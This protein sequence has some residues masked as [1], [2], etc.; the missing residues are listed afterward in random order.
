MGSS[1]PVPAA[2]LALPDLQGRLPRERLLRLLDALPS[3]ARG[4]WVMAAAGGGKSVLMAQW[5]QRRQ[6]QTD[7]PALWLRLDA[8]DADPATLATHLHEAL[9]LHGAVPGGWPG[10]TREQLATPAAALRRCMRA[11]CAALPP[12]AT[13]V[14]DDVHLLPAASPSLQALPV[15]LDELRAGQT[16]WLLSRDEPPPALALA[17]AAGGLARVD[18]D[19]LRFDTEELAAWLHAA[20][21]SDDAVT[22]RQR[23][24]GWPLLLAMAAASPMADDLALVFEQALWST[25]DADACTLLERLAWLPAAGVE[26]LGDDGIALL[27][28]LQRSGLPVEGLA[29]D[30]GASCRYRLHDLLRDDARR[31]QR[32]RLSPAA[33]SAALQAQAQALQALGQDEAAWPLW[34]EAA[35]ADAAAWPAAVA[36]L[37]ALAPRWLATQQLARLRDAVDPVPE[38][39][40][41]AALWAALAQAEAPRSPARARALADRAAALASPAQRD[42]QLACQ[43]LAIATH[44]QNFDDTR[45]LAD[46]VAALQGLGVQVGNA[47]PALALAVWSALFL[48]DP[49]H[50]ELSRWRQRVLDLLHDERADPN[51]RPRAAMLMA[52]EGWYNGRHADLLQLPALVQGA[53]S[54]PGV[55]PYGRLLWGLMR[56]Y[57]AWAGA[58]WA[59]GLQ[60]TTQ[61]LADAQDSGITLLDSHLRL[62]GACFASLVGDEPQADAWMHAVAERADPARRME[63]WHHFSVRGWLALRRGDAAAAV[64]AAR[65]GAEAGQAMG[66]APQ[67]MALAVGC[68]ALQALDD[69]AALHSQLAALRALAAGNGLA[70]AH[71]ALI[72]ARAAMCRDDPDAALRVLGRLLPALAAQGLWAPIGAAPPAL[73]ALLQLALDNVVEVDTAARMVRA[74]RLPPPPGAGARWPWPVRVLTR[75]RFEVQIDGQP[76]RSQGKAQRRPLELLQALID[77]GGQA[78]ATALAD[79]L[80]PDAEGDQAMAAFEVALRRLRQLLGLPQGLRLSGGLLS[81]DPQQIWV[82][83]L[84]DEAFI[85]RS[86]GIRRSSVASL[87]LGAS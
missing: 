15:L 3:S 74:L 53:L 81:L 56:Q 48:R 26:L 23:S 68:H 66:P 34:A 44:F 55:A 62:H 50:A 79:R 42:L 30:S 29:D 10:L 2:H 67:A 22:L 71:L 40:R 28:R 46:R 75:G 5:L 72:D 83:V 7:Q 45:P 80:W 4:R 60:A 65:I 13:L 6:Q 57:A 85:P 73:A 82:D 70:Q 16:L 52:K 76:L 21:R 58:D 14:L 32:R 47:T 18:G 59:A 8:S 86:Q 37:E 64:A 38:D 35:G 12:G 27:R 9:S 36:A 24:G 87:E 20:G 78:S 39:R 1:I 61:A 19:A 84:A 51:L 54:A 17:Q 77:A 11:L 25:L 33:L 43:A 41:S 49:A 63:A 69:G 31:R